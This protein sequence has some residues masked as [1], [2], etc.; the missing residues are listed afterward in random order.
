[1]QAYGRET[2][3]VRIGQP[4]LPSDFVRTEYIHADGRLESRLRSLMKD[5]AQR[6]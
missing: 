4:A 2:A 3:V 1:M 5:I 6:T